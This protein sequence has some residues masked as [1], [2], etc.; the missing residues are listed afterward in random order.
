MAEWVLKLNP[1]DEVKDFANAV[2]E[3]QSKEIETMQQ[4]M[5]AWMPKW[6]QRGGMMRR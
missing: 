3:A 6:M 2:I 5:M 4:L 1:R